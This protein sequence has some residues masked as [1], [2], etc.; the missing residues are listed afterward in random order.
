MNCPECGDVCRCSPELAPVQWMP[1]SDSSFSTLVSPIPGESEVGQ[2]VE[3][4]GAHA[5]AKRC[6]LGSE[7]AMPAESA[8]LPR[9]EPVEDAEDSQRSD[10]DG[11][12][13]AGEEAPAWRGEVTASLDRYRAR[14]KARPPR[15]PSLRLRFEPE[16]NFRDFTPPSADA[17]PV[18]P[19]TFE[20]RSHRA[21]ALDSPVVSSRA[22]ELASQSLPLEPAT[23]STAP[24]LPPAHSG[25]KIIEFPRSAT[26]QPAPPRDELAEP[27]IARPR[28]LEAPE[29]TL[30]P[31]LGG[32]TIDPLQQKEIERRPG[33]DFPLQTAPLARRIVAA[34]LD[35]LIITMGG[36]LFGFVF[37]EVTAVQP[38][39]LQTL[40][41]A[42]AVPCLLWAAYQ[43]L[44]IVYCGSTPGLRLAGLEITHFDG[45]TTNRRCRRWRV[46]ASYLSAISL[47]MGYA[48]LFL[49]EDS[50]CWHDRITHTYLAPKQRQ[51]PSKPA[52][53]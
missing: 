48:W 49:D 35:W 23:P 31:A 19:G 29:I 3:A 17:S 1:E 47:G 37:W 30:P 53:S 6:A 14:R 34:A 16:A 45:A 39:R 50:L 8:H 41:L 21:L 11:Q 52:Q 9:I 40:G 15:Y 2:L 25:A 44:L 7:S 42:A 27:V 32:I 4:E 10:R 36:L 22:E 24:S 43:Y 51:T 38:P 26:S 28:I 46:L 5:S 18:S 12:T 33:I 13:C 20:S